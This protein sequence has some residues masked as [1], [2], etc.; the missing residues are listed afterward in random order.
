[1][2]PPPPVSSQAHILLEKGER[3][4]E[5]NMRA[6]TIVGRRAGPGS[7]TVALHWPKRTPHP[8]PLGSVF[9]TPQ[10]LCC[11]I[12][13]SCGYPHKTNSGK[14]GAHRRGALFSKI[15]ILASGSYYS[16]ATNPSF[17]FTCHGMRVF[18]SSK[19]DDVLKRQMD[20]Q[21]HGTGGFP[22]DK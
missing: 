6:T 20:S 1:M 4:W 13:G 2:L 10:P 22:G 5:D 14:P 7:S 3:D 12:H 11:G 15:L 19:N 16:L 9:W 21:C 18:L 17:C 8:A